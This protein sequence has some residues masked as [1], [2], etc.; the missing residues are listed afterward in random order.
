MAIDRRKEIYIQ[1]NNPKEIADVLKDIRKESAEVKK[2]F[3]EY[4]KLNLEEN[5]IFDNWSNY[6]EDSLEKL[7]HVTL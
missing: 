4:D 2:L 5:K 1:V 6:I 3:E 7:E